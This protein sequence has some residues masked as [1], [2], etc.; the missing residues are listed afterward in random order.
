M[1]EPVRSTPSGILPWGWVLA[2]VVVIAASSFAAAMLIPQVSR[3]SAITGASTA[4]LAFLGTQ[5]GARI[6]YRM[7][8]RTRRG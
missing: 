3:R 7:K 6:Y 2:A 4:A 8:R 1:A 5:L